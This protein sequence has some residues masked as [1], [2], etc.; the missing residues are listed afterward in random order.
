[1]FSSPPVVTA[2]SISVFKG[3]TVVLS[4][5]NFNATDN[6]NDKIFT[7]NVSN[8]THGVFQTT[9]DGSHWVEATSFT[10]TDIG[11]G[12]VRFV[13]DNSGLAPTFLVQADNG[14]TINNLSDIKD[15]TV[16]FV[17]NHVAPQVTAASFAVVEG[18]LVVL[19]ASNFSIKDADSSNFTFTVSNV[20]HGSFQAL[21]NGNWTDTTTFTSADL[22][23]AHVRF[24]TDGSDF[25]PTFSVQV[26][27]GQPSN[28]LSSVFTGA[29][30]FTNDAAPLITAASF[31]V[32]EGASVVLAA[33]NFNIADSDS[34][35][36]GFTVS[37]V[38]H[39][40]F[41]LFVADGEGGHW[42]NTT[43]FS[44]ADLGAGHVRFLADG[45]DY[46]PTFSVQVDNGEVANHQSNLFAGSV[47]F[48]NDAAPLITAA[49]FAV[50][51]GA[52]VVLAASNFN[53]TDSDSSSFGFTVSSVAHGTFQL[54][55]AD[56]EGGHWADT[57]TFGSADLAAGHVRFL[58]DGSDYTP[59]FSV[60]VDN[61]EV[62]NHQSNLFAGSVT[63]TN[64]PPPVITAASFS[65]N[66]GA[67][68]V[69]AASNF[70]IT[71]SDSSSFGFTVSSVAHGT[72]QL[73][74]ADG[75]G[76][77]WADTTTFGSADLAA[78]HVRFLADGSDYT[79]TFSVQVDNGEVV[80]HQSNL[81]AGSVTFTND[82]PPV[83]TAASF[84]VNEGASVVL[85][86][87]NFNITDPDGSSFGFTVSNVA[88][89]TFQLFV[90]DGE[91]GH[92]AD[93]TTF[94][95]ADLAAGHVRFLA[96]GSDYAPTF[97]VQVDN[98]EVVNHQSNLFAGSVTFTNDPPP[99]ITA[100]SFTV[101]DGQSTALSTSNFGIT[102]ADPNGNNFT[103]SVASSHGHFQL[104]DGSN[105]T[106]VTTFTTADLAAGHVRFTADSSDLQPTF[107]VQVD[108]GE[109]VNHQS[110]QFTGS[111]TFIDPA[112]AI[113]AASFTVNQGDTVLLSTS[114]FGVSDPDDASFTFLVS[115]VANGHFQ[116]FD[117]SHWNDVTS[118]TTADLAAHH[119]RFAADGSDFAPTFT[120]EA[121]NGDPI[122][123]LSDPFT[124]TVTFTNDP[125]PVITA[126]SFAVTE[127]QSVVL[128]A[129]NFSINDL[130]PNGTNFTYTVSNVSHGSFQTTTDGSQWTT[131]TTFTSA[132]LSA[133]HVRFL[134]D[135]GDSTPTFAVQVDD[136]TPV[137]HLSNVLAGTVQFTHVNDAPVITGTT[138]TGSVPAGLLTA[139]AASY[140]LASHDLINTLGGSTG[141][142]TSIGPNDDGSS[143]LLG[144]HGRVWSGR[145]E[146]L[147]PQLHAPLGQQ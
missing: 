98:G 21:I 45:S 35:S 22:A 125:V 122:N 136:G 61:G 83:I 42:A 101:N 49:S 143:R 128:A 100:A 89:G 38:A 139:T 111:I 87:S 47:N 140:L 27:D 147:R 68:V 117:G 108:N 20:S 18:N 115:N 76:G 33:S 120:I 131:V 31:A 145:A 37:N 62:V 51:E 86:A 53:I 40:T 30:N 112:P 103:F 138:A 107:T 36:F 129:S 146:F 32:N 54:F 119:V 15:G 133:N 95:S 4:T 10:T 72:F 130:D 141:F 92:W 28:N 94:G 25:Q 126:A 80:N 55:V 19:S 14:Q 118:F 57:T 142:G 104:F 48:T 34:S 90:A 26:D 93:T 44:S 85:A 64:D 75:E 8:V 11:L 102:D 66:E 59:T 7:F 113:T 81:F 16:Q 77:H 110:N 73:F 137:N 41:Q 52:S 91:G 46:T 3:E 56:G 78:G 135:G 84:S 105:W 2:A 63:F 123:H 39:G 5:T 6:N 124:G 60:Q 69:L 132:Q 65:V 1:M 121:D 29:V 23:A 13:A 144:S 17:F 97:S 88:H 9:T 12:H 114:N 43:T 50:N 96:D 99:V 82:P 79:P 67:S 70:N 74:V 116:L 127:H 109:V 134:Q 58:A 106:N 24:H 71:D